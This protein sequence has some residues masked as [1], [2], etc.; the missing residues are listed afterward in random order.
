MIVIGAGINGAAIAREAAL[1]G[2][3]VLLVERSDLAAGT[4]SASS[5][6]IHGGLRYLEHFE[7]GLVRESLRERERLLRSAP[8]LVAPLELC[9]PVYAHARR[10]RWQIA[11]GLTLYDW[12]SADRSLPG[13]TLLTRDAL[14]AKLPGMSTDGLAGGASY[15]DAQARY[16][17]RLVVENVLDAAAN[18]AVVKTYTRVTRIVVEGGRANGVEWRTASGEIGGARAR[19][20]VN[21]AGPWVDE[22]LGTIQHT[23]LI[24]GTKGSHLIAPPFSGAP[25]V[26]VYVEAGSDGRPLFI[27]PW[28]G[29]LLVGTTDERV[30]EPSAA[31]MTRR[32]LEYLARETERVF[33]AAAGLASRALYTYT[34][35]RP[36]PYQP[37]GAEGAI[38]RRHIIRRHRAARGL[39]SIVG[40][41][42]TTHRALAEDVLGVVRGQLPGLERRR[43]T[44]DRPLPGALAPKERDELLADVGATLNA[45]QAARLWGVYGAAALKIAELARS[46]PE[47][48]ATVG[49]GA[50]LVAELVY[51]REV[52]WAVTLDDILQRRCMAGLDA[53][54][55]LGAAEPAARW[56]VRLGVWDSARAESE[57][58]DYRTR[59]ARQRAPAG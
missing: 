11:V 38:T 46:S 51:A 40:G 56:L 22:A 59:A 13:H 24:G 9:I 14:L 7:L 15:F 43:P 50:T 53:D 12:L 34:G 16:P 8:H 35:V 49:A 29:L 48:A 44:R 4:S 10:K 30:E 37:R 21:A 26:G 41:K 57:L 52:E 27:L 32:E 36:L 45:S 19:V 23:R 5:R 2:L 25:S 6:L 47:L 18:A 17:E 39:Y 58:A 1:S 33:P 55:G 31:A 54:F 42:L 20:I 3:A 28:N